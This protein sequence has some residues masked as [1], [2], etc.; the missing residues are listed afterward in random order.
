MSTK[1]CD[2]RTAQRLGAQC[3]LI[4]L[5]CVLAVASVPPVLMWA[6]RPGPDLGPLGIWGA[7]EA[8]ASALSILAGVLAVPIGIGAVL[9]ALRGDILGQIR[10]TLGLARDIL[11]VAALATFP[12]LI[13]YLVVTRFGAAIATWGSTYLPPIALVVGILTLAAVLFAGGGALIGRLVARRHG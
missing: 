9:G 4:L 2:R 5:G 3:G 13:G 7:L 6:T 11:F 1:T 10:A 8:W 12:V